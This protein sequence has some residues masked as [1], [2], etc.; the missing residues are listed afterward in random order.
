MNS[1]AMCSVT[2]AKVARWISGDER[3][4]FDA[5]FAIPDFQK[6]LVVA[7]ASELGGSGIEIDTVI[8]LRMKEIA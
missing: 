1:P 2:R 3:P 5:L 7:L 4:H 8:R 6:H